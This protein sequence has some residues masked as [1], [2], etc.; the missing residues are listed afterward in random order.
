MAFLPLP[1]PILL[2][3]LRTHLDSCQK[4]KDFLIVLYPG[5]LGANVDYQK[6]SL[7]GI[8]RSLRPHRAYAS[9][10]VLGNLRVVKEWRKIK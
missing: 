1:D 4:L 10:K 8:H 2:D 9:E 3:R 5:Y 7:K 6:E